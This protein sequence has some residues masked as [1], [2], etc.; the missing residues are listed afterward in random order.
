MR[1][2]W[3]VRLPDSTQIVQVQTR[4]FHIRLNP[5]LERRDFV[6]ADEETAPVIEP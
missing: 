4:Y 5:K 1:E 2:S 3:A 6:R